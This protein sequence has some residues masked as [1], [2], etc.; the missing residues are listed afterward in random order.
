VNIQY[1]F[2][3]F[4]EAFELINQRY[5]WYC[6]YLSDVNAD[7][8]DYIIEKLMENLNG[9]KVEPFEV[10]SLQNIESG[11]VSHLCQQREQRPMDCHSE[12]PER[13]LA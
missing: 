13:K 6:M 1:T 11:A 10:R 2:S 3:T 5:P 4:E 7:Y 9:K 8:Q 12:L